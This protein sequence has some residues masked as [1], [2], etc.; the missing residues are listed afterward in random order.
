[1]KFPL[2]ATVLNNIPNSSLLIF[3]CFSNDSKMILEYLVFL[4]ISWRIS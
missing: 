3:L 4:L 1:M 2:N